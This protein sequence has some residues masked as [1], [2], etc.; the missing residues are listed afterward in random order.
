VLL[1]FA[2]IGM[3][4]GS[5][6]AH[7]GIGDEHMKQFRNT[8]GLSLAE[9]AASFV[10]L[11]PVLVLIVYTIS[12]VAHVYMIKEGLSEAA[13]RAARDVSAAYH[14][15]KLVATNRSLQDRVY[16]NIRVPNV[17]HDPSQFNDAVFD[18]N[19]TPQTV[20]VRV[21]F[22]SAQFGLPRFPNVDPLNLQ[23]VLKLNAS[24]TYYVEPWSSSN[25]L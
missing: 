11:L 3:H 4:C 25:S 24:A 2:R 18:L 10:V 13:R 8:R 22:R 14:G 9:T 15:S 1:L 7:T 20:T 23:N 21:H 17:V 6:S 19:S 5:G 12:E 16:K